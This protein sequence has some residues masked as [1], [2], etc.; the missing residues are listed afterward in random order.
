MIRSPGNVV[1]TALL[2]LGSTS[3]HAE[4]LHVDIANTNPNY[5]SNF[6]GLSFDLDTSATTDT[7]ATGGCYG[8]FCLPGYY[9]TFDAAGGMSNAS[10]IWNGVDYS[11][12]S[13]TISLDW[14]GGYVFDLNMDLTFNN[15]ASF[16]TDDQSG[17]GA[18]SY[19]QYNPSQVLAAAVTGSYNAYIV[20]GLLEVDGQ[21]TG[22]SGL[23]AKTTPVPEPGT[24]AL[25]TVGLAGIAV[26]RRRGKASSPASRASVASV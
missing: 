14:Q 1:V 15:G 10:F 26:V 21:P 22:D 2:I 4:I 9:T 25:L 19:S 12:Q 8:G 16:R 18:Y 24:L 20:A 3:V 17:A 6:G 13:S 11:L 5:N 23:V 7:I